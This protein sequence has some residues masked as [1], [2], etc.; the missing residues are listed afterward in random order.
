MKKILLFASVILLLFICSSCKPSNECN[1]KNIND[2]IVCMFCG[3]E[4]P[5]ISNF[6]QFCGSPLKNQDNLE[7]NGNDENEDNNKDNN[8]ENSNDSNKNNEEETFDDPSLLK[9][10]I[11]IYGLKMKINSADCVNIYVDWENLSIKEI[12][13]MYF[14]V[15]LYNRVDDVLTCNNTGEQDIWIYQTGPI[16]QGKG[17]Y[18]VYSYDSEFAKRPYR[19][20]VPYSEYKNDEMNGWEGIYWDS[21]WYNSQAYYVKI[22]G[23]KIEYKDGTVYKTKDYSISETFVYHISEIGDYVHNFKN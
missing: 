8:E 3:E 13:Y 11:K 17:M 4:I 5:A 10:L 7:N 6:C 20:D 12:K 9:E 16:P 21:V 15:E 2:D 1:D 22:I 23:V 14:N 19:P 18:N